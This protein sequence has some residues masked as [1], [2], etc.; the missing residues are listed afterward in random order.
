MTDFAPTDRVLV[1]PRYL[2]G[3]GTDKISDVIGSLVH[4]FDWQAEQN[5]QRVRVSHPQGAAALE[6]APESPDGQW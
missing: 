6:F 3:A 2:A 5:P 4:F 1:S